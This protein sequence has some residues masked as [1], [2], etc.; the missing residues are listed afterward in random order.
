M[1]QETKKAI[2][3]VYVET[4]F[5]EC[6][7]YCTDENIISAEY[8]KN[9]IL[10][11]NSNEELEHEVVSNFFDYLGINEDEFLEISSEIN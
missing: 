7:L 1:T 8:E 3:E 4:S 9:I 10:Q 11:Y 5:K 6:V 2:I